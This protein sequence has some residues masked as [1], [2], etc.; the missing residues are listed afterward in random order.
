M[1]RVKECHHFMNRGTGVSKKAAGLKET[2]LKLMRTVD[3]EFPTCV[4]W[5]ISFPHQ[6][7]VIVD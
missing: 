2:G 5:N 3:I 1:K 4:C 6:T 7:H